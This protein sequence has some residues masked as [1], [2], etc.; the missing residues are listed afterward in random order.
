MTK[1]CPQGQVKGT[2]E[3]LEVLV[4]TNNRIDSFLLCSVPKECGKEESV[5][6]W[7]GPC[8]CR[9]NGIRVRHVSVKPL[10][11]M[12]ISH[13]DAARGYCTDVLRGVALPDAFV[14]SSI[15]CQAGA[16]QAGRRTVPT[17]AS[18]E[19]E[20]GYSV[21]FAALFEAY[22]CSCRPLAIRKANA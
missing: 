7:P 8:T 14:R 16:S 17:N 4:E 11:R 12:Y 21:F 20:C 6:W 9:E 3:V 2:V 5:A 10:A 22:K 18:Y 1:L 19:D 13:W 15:L